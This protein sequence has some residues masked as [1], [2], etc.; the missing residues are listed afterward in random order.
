METIL[1]PFLSFLLLYKYMALFLV[2][3]TAAFLIPIPASSVLAASGAFAYQGYLNIYIVLIV[4][5]AGNIAG[6]T[7]GYLLARYYGEKLLTKAGFRRLLKS[8]SY[9][10]IKN[11]IVDFPQSLIYFSRFLIELGPAVNILSGLSEVP[12]KTYFLFE[13]L[14]EAS[15]VFIYG[16]IGYLLGTQWENNVGFLAKITLVIL[17]LGLII[18]L[19]Q[20]FLFNKRRKRA[21]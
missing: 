20:I 16:M 1:G 17:P 10:K 13:V 18:N 3:F 4:A 15:Y 6:D 21:K 14:G 11:Y 7:L 2:A 12:P 8:S 9:E 5:L 19:S